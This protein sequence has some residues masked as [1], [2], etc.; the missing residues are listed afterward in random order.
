LCFA[1]F[2]K[3][4]ARAVPCLPTPQNTG[5]SFPQPWTLIEGSASVFVQFQKALEFV[6]ENWFPGSLEQLTVYFTR[7]LKANTPTLL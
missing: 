3:M 4:S 6:V 5:I 1:A 2:G 7:D